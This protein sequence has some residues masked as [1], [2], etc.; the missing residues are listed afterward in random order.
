MW[1]IIVK[2]Y[3]FIWWHCEWWIIPT[4]RKPFSDFMHNFI[5]SHVTE[6]TIMILL[7]YAGMLAW[8]HWVLFWPTLVAI[9]GTFLLTHLLWGVQ[10]LMKLAIERKLL[11]AE[12]LKI[13]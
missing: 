2:I 5:I 12:H 6:A 3:F 13:Q 7:F 10:T 1:K 4:G 11:T 8:S 9:T